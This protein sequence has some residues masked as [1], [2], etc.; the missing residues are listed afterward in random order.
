MA[1]I[2]RLGKVER[3]PER[4]WYV[5]TD[6]GEDIARSLDMMKHLDGGAVTMIAGAPGVGKTRTLSNFYT[7]AEASL[8]QHCA[9]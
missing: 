3:P 5:P 4:S 9:G 6:T 2:P 8:L 7:V 1:E